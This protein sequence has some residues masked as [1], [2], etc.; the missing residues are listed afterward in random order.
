MEFY[1]GGKGHVL[2]GLRGQKVKIIQGKELPKAMAKASH[3]CVLQLIPQML[4]FQRNQNLLV[5][6]LSMEK[7]EIPLVIQL[8]QQFEDLFQAI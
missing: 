8:L 2:R 5:Q 3:L 6:Q 4:P 1:F 7:E